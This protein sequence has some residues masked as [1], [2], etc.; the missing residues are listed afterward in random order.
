M[1]LR[2]LALPVTGPVKG[3]GWILDQLLQTA[4]AQLR[5]AR[6]EELRCALEASEKSS[7]EPCR[8]SGS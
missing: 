5:E 6:L 1:I 8:P 7:P 2:L 4:E 3:A